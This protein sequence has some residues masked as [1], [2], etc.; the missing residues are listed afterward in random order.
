[1]FTVPLEL[2]RRP[3]VAYKTLTAL[4][5]GFT[6]KHA[7]SDFVAEAA[8]ASHGLQTVRSLRMLLQDAS[9]TA[10]A[11]A[12]A[13]ANG[14]AKASA[15]AS[16]SAGKLIIPLA[17]RCPCASAKAASRQLVRQ[18]LIVPSCQS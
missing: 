10:T 11:A 5:A 3:E 1:M 8:A 14:F 13:A 6:R 2:T 17:T 7:G 18:L 4:L 15:S 16:A 12:T 9:A